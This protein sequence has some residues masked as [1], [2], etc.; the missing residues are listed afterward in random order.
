MKLTRTLKISETEFYDYL[1]SDLLSR[2]DGPGN[3]SPYSGRIQK[4]LKY[5]KFENNV[6]ARVDV[7]ILDYQR[8]ALYQAQMKTINDTITI[9]YR[10]EAVAGGLRIE[11]TQLIESFESAHHFKLM[12]W[13]SEGVYLGRMTDALYAIQTAIEK[14]RTAL[15]DT[16]SMICDKH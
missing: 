7:T 13:F 4:G 12:Q 8:N 6:N 15:T 5:S 3:D 11:F 10:T 9:T 1:E 14:Q 16:E 2:I